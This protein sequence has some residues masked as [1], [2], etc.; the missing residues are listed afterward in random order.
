MRVIGR[1]LSLL[2]ALPLAMATSYLGFCFLLIACYAIVPPPTTGV[3]IQ[4]R[5]EAIV[6]GSAYTKK[7]HPVSRSKISGHLPHALVAAED[8]QFY[9]HGG[10]D[11][12]AVRKA[13]DDNK[14]RGRA[15]R[16]G[17]GITQQTVKNL[18]QT[19][20]S[21]GW[22]RYA[23]KAFEVPLVYAAEWTLS[24]ERI[25]TLYLN[26]I[27]WGPGVYGAQAAAQHHYSVDA[28]KLSRRQSASLAAV[29][30]APRSRTPG[31]MG[32]YTGIIEARMRQM[33]W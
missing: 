19:T 11:W 1:I 30:P 7:Y 29:V 32:R 33:G 6:S 9:Q 13:L 20:H 8:G 5:V 10:I 12:D 23:R 18:F 17:S 28:A 2:V 4:R 21:S 25:L 16:G 15:W 31:R 3:Q 24:K 22:R 27:E 14:R 26:V